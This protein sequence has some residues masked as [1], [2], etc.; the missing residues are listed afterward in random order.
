M[1]FLTY[2]NMSGFANRN[3]NDKIYI[4]VINA[5]PET[6]QEFD[7]RNQDTF[8]EYYTHLGISTIYIDVINADPE[9]EQEFDMRNQ[10]T[11]GEYFFIIDFDE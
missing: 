11:F 6:E 5:D 3:V 4:D 10:D 8:G 2:N 1:E 9:T 7:M